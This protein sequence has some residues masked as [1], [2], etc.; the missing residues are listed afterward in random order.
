MVPQNHFYSNACLY[1]LIGINLIE[2]KCKLDS[3]ERVKFNN[4]LI[5]FYTGI[6]HRWTNN[7]IYFTKNW[8]RYI[9]MNLKLVAQTLLWLTLLLLCWYEINVK[10]VS[11]KWI[12]LYV[13]IIKKCEWLVAVAC[14]EPVWGRVRY[15]RCVSLP[16]DSRVTCTQFPL[17][18]FSQ[19]GIHISRTGKLALSRLK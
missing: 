8:R 6:I 10:G 9:S 19:Q 4:V 18:T 1:K 5:E 13:V 15:M 16:K 11:K 7:I 14:R 17:V 2:F 3:F 12:P